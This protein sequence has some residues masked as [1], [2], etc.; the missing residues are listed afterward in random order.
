MASRL[1]SLNSSCCKVKIFSRISLRLPTI[2][3]KGDEH[4]VN[5]IGRVNVNLIF[6]IYLR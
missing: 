4:Q 2:C 1:D 5:K 6:I 3:Q